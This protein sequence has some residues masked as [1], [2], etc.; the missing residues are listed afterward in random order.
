MVEVFLKALEKLKSLDDL[1]PEVTCHA[2]FIQLHSLTQTHNSLS[3]VS[4]DVS[5]PM[6]QI[7]ESQKQVGS[8]K[9]S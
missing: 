2:D 4:I 5:D 1:Q 9:N 3:T 7:K 6:D 8:L